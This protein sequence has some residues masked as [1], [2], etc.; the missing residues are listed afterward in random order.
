M[1]MAA[2]EY[3]SVSSQADVE[4]ADLE[5]EQREL[6]EDEDAEEEELASIYVARGLSPS[7]ASE[8]A[9]QLME[10]DALGS[11]MRDELGLYEAALAR[12]LQAALAS[13]ASFA[14]GALL[15]LLVAVVSP[16]EA[17]HFSV[18]VV[19]LAT[20]ALLGG[21]SARAGAAPVARATLRVSFWGAAAMAATAAI[22]ALFGQVVS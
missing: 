22:G 8:V 11:H 6:A 21:L 2:G 12:P 17:L 13:A 5:R 4:R 15:P 1:S 10:H 18:P 3:V 9:E 20:L 14:L 16:V 19:S 7:L